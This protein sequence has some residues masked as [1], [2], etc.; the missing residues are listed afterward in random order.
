MIVQNAVYQMISSSFFIRLRYLLVSYN[1]ADFLGFVCAGSAS[2]QFAVVALKD[3]P[4]W[5]SMANT[6]DPLNEC[7]L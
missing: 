6:T 5:P 2:L 4:M 7:R 1:I 3:I